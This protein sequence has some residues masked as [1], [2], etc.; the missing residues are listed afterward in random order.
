MRKETI[1][2]TLTYAG[3]LPFLGAAGLSI[4]APDFSGANYK[5]IL[6]AY[7]A[8]IASFIAGIHWGIFLFKESP[9]NLFIHSNVIALL[10]W[11]AMALSMTSSV[12]I[13]IF[14]FLYLLFIDQKLSNAQIIESWYMRMRIH[15]S[16]IVILTLGTHFLLGNA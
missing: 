9:L 1:A 6:L 15:A 10:A 16:V 13:L 8:V 14:C 11:V 5:H 3:I 4:F 2:K 12:L 7:G